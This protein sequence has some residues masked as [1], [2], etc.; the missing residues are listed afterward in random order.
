MPTIHPVVKLTSSYLRD[1]SA[2][3]HHIEIQW[4]AHDV[5]L[6][7]ID[8]SALYTSIPHQ[9]G[10]KKVERAAERHYENAGSHTRQIVECF[11]QYIL[12]MYVFTFA[13]YSYLH[14]HGTAMGAKTATCLPISSWPISNGPPSVSIRHRGDRRTGR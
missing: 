10:I 2:F 1:S 14:H 9:E 7:T 11:L 13:G 6:V 8:V 5:L 3:V 12:K 4:Y